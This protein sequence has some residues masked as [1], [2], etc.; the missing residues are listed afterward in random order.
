MAKIVGAA[1]FTAAILESASAFRARHKTKDSSTAA[2]STVTDESHGACA[3]HI[4]HVRS[5]NPVYIPLLCTAE[6]TSLEMKFTGWGHLLDK[7]RF[8]LNGQWMGEKTWP[9]FGGDRTWSVGVGSLPAGVH[10]LK[11]WGEVRMNE[12]KLEGGGAASCS[13]DIGPDYGR[14]EDSATYGGFDA[15]N[16]LFGPEGVRFSEFKKRQAYFVEESLGQN[17]DGSISSHVVQEGFWYWLYDYTQNPRSEDPLGEEDGWSGLWN[18]ST[19][20]PWKSIG[21][22]AM[23]GRGGQSMQVIEPCNTLSSLAFNEATVWI[24]CK[25][26][27]FTR[28]EMASLITGF[29]A[30]SAGTAFQ[31]VTGT[32]VGG[33]ADVFAMKHLMLQIYQIMVRSVVEQAG[34]NLT[35]EEKNAVETFGYSVGKVTDL[36]KQMTRLFSEKYD[37]DYWEEQTRAVDIPDYMKSI[38]GL[39]IFA[40]Y[41][42]EGAIPIPGLKDALG[43]LTT[44]LMDAFDVPGK[45]YFV[46]TYIPAAQKALSFS[47]MCLDSV[48]PVLE[49]IAKFAVVFIEALIFQE[50]TI[51]VPPVVR[52]VLAFF[53][54]LGLTGSL[55]SDMRPT[56]DYYNGFDCVSRSDHTN[57]HEK[58]SHGLIHFVTI[59]ELFLTKHTC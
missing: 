54:S 46:N 17:E 55:L 36:S 15:L 11:F 38:T 51:P 2:W 49:H 9:F 18:E 33:H 53:D 13:F 52:D 26:L 39:V 47:K 16:N 44:A 3:E 41:G 24:S 29:N 5:S 48:M 50:K 6:A 30:L 32:R 8:E 42:V 27:P 59:A 45:E 14:T 56:W 4:K 21:L 25:G 28:D 31:H 12:V 43:A 20:M 34:D 23:R 22:G 37:R 1:C 58:A 10:T 57:W 40:L 7:M 35:P 19:I